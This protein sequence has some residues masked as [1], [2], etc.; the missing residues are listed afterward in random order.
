MAT[1]TIGTTPE[2]YART[3]GVLYALL[4]F[5]GPAAFFMGRTSVYVPG[6][7][8][9]TVEGLMAAE[10]T[11]RTGMVAETAI[12]IIEILTSAML[13]VLFRPVN[14]PLSLASSFARFGQAMLQAVNL[15]TAVPAL[16]LLG[17]AGY[18]SVFEPD[19]LNALVLM[20]MD[21][22]AFVI[23]IWGLIFGFHL[24]L[25][26]YLV[27]RSGFLP[28]FLGILLLIGAAG[29]LLQSYGHLL[30]PQFDDILSTAVIFMSVP[31][32]LGFTVWL[33]IKGVNGERWEERALEAG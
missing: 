11:F 22:N 9:A 30:A 5:L 6:D 25:L 33:L 7:P 15:L 3:I 32:E 29:Y 13:Y 17:G 20:F 14:Q 4:F 16:L 19:Q 12:V 18:L 26:G 31:G 27:L 23:M 2:A 10:S 24:V 1:R 21:M 8:A 28:K